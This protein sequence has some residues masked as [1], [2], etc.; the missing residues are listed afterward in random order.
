MSK[1]KS[2]T[3]KGWSGLYNDGTLGWC[4]SYFVDPYPQSLNEHQREVLGILVKHPQGW[5]NGDM[6][7]VQI[8]VTPIKNK[9]GKYIIKRARRAR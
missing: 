6:Y 1:L 4:V 5:C 3:G 9:R 2:V 8:T 7:R